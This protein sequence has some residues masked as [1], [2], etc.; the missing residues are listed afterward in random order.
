M[1]SFKKI[2]SLFLSKANFCK[3]KSTFF[4]NERFFSSQLKSSII[5]KKE[6][7]T[8]MDKILLNGY[9]SIIKIDDGWQFKTGIISLN[10]I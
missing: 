5:S 6:F 2:H 1:L 3:K 7:S 8:C 9:E 4:P 10:Y